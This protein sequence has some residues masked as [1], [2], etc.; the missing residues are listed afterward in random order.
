MASNEAAGRAD[1]AAFTCRRARSAS[2]TVAIGMLL[3]VETGGFHALLLYLGHPL[4]AWTLTLLSLTALAWLISDYRA[5]GTAAIH[6]GPERMDLRIGRR[7]SAVV[8]RTALASIIAPTWR[9]LQPGEDYL[10]G[11]KPARPNVMLTFRDPVSVTLLGAVRRPVRRIGLHLDEPE[12]FIAHLGP[13][14]PAST[15]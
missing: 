15:N 12:R 13:A 11:T 9:D 2:I 5:M 10:N 7:I 1:E 3:V 6:V 8:P 4:A 14:F